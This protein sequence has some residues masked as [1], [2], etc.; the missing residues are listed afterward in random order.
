MR[1]GKA[2]FGTMLVDGVE[3]AIEIAPL[4][5]LHLEVGAWIQRVPYADASSGV[6]ERLESGSCR[7]RPSAAAAARFRGGAVGRRIV[8][9]AGDVIMTC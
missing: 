4:A 9:H 7:S 5:T 8:H 1:D 6:L 2:A 3:Y